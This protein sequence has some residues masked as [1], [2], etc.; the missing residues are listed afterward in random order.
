VGALGQSSLFYFTSGSNSTE[1]FYAMTGDLCVNTIGI[2]ITATTTLTATQTKAK[3]QHNVAY[4]T[5]GNSR[6]LGMPFCCSGCRIKPAAAMP[7]AQDPA[8]HR[9]P[10]Q[11]S[12]ELSGTSIAL[13]GAV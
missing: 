5:Q 9:T 10:L 8:Q 4:T 2:V 7:P 12:W 11:P 1:G 3:I 6:C 13:V